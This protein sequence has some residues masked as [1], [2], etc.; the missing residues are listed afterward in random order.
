LLCGLV[1]SRT[2]QTRLLASVSFLLLAGACAH[3]P[4]LGSSLDR[5][6][7]PAFI[8]RIEEGAGPRSSVFRDDNSY[9]VKL[10][11]LSAK[12]GDRRLAVKLA[13]GSVDAVGNRGITLTRFQL[14]DTLRSQ[15][16]ANIA[17]V[18]P[19][20]NAAHP[21]DVAAVLQSFLVQEVPANPPDYELL[22]PL[23]VDAVIEFVVE[24]Y[25]M[26]SVGGMAGCYIS[27]FGRMFRLDGGGDMWFRRFKADQVKSGQASM[28]PFQ[29]A[30]DTNIFRNEMG[31]LLAA[32]ADVFAADL[33]PAD[34]GAPTSNDRTEDAR[35]TTPGTA[36]VKP[37]TVPPEEADPL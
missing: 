9:T 24:E 8:S 35:P 4:L 31:T 10:K 30:K 34:R 25:G 12:E 14:A 16:T 11:R 22:R 7:R 26:R 23:G 5:V 2:A 6:N 1:P 17:K 15:V 18:A 13:E 33:S 32:V 20:T 29:V 3:K 28:D 37:R 19:W 36:P 27:G 21:G